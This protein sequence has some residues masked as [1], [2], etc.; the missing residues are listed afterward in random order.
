MA[1]RTVNRF[2]YGAKTENENDEE[3][4]IDK[5]MQVNFSSGP[6]PV[7]LGSIALLTATSLDRNGEKERSGG[8]FQGSE[9]YGLNGH[10]PPRVFPRSAIDANGAVLSTA[11]RVAANPCDHRC[12][13]SGRRRRIHPPIDKIAPVSNPHDFLLTVQVSDG[14]STDESAGLAAPIGTMKEMDSLAATL[15][16]N[17]ADVIWKAA[18]AGS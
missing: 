15:N 7:R 3:D 2:L 12:I 8:R 10:V 4:S 18:I 11:G 17:S 1:W 6:A 16:R 14:I 9:V 13:G 5:S